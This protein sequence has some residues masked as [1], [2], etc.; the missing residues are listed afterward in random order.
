VT[1][2]EGFLGFM[3]FSLYIVCIFTVCMITFK[4]GHWLLG[5][6][7]IILPWL[8]LIGAILPAKK[9]SRYEIEQEIAWQRQVEQYS[10]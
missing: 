1:Y 3:F 6:L 4:K 2:A 9:G 5:I 10:Q 7:G 8:W